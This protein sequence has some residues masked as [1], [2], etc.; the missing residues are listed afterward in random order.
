MTART[1]SPDGV[2]SECAAVSQR[3]GVA[4]R[5]CGVTTRTLRYWQEIG[6]LLPSGMSEGGER[7]YGDEDVK[8]AAR[9]KELQELLGFSLSEIRVVLETEDILDRVRSAYRADM[10][11][12]RQ[13]ELLS[14]AIEANDTLLA[15]L[16]D[17]LAR[18]RAFRRERAQK[19][20]RL[21]AR[22]AELESEMA[23]GRIR[24]K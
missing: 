14:E 3:I 10:R 9:I 20:D 8:R 15:R 19:A 22:V 21:R 11:P 7:L 24:A 12:A 16:D 5:A 13:L 2:G 18:V 23:R 1:E 4:A 6:L 17:T